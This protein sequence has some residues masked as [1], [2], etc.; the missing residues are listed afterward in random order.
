M[1]SVD[2]SGRTAMPYSCR[3]TEST[4]TKWRMQNWGSWNSE[5]RTWLVVTGKIQSDTWWRYK[6][7]W[8]KPKVWNNMYLRCIS[9]TSKVSGLM[10]LRLLQSSTVIQ[11]IFCEKNFFMYK[12]LCSKIFVLYKHLSCILMV[13]VLKYFVFNVHSLRRVRKFLTTIHVA[14]QITVLDLIHNIQSIS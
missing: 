4:G 3:Y 7:N 5:Q 14:S 2:K 13:H 9:E 11:E 8:R 6:N 10:T 1:S 12:S